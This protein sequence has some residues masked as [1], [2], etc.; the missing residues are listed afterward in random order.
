MLV[1]TFLFENRLDGK[2]RQRSEAFIVKDNKLLVC[3]GRESG[4]PSLPGGK[5]EKNES[6]KTAA[7]RETLE[8]VGIKIKIIRKLKNYSFDYIKEIGPWET[9]PYEITRWDEIGMETHPFLAEYV[10][11]DKSLYNSEGDGKLYKWMTSKE[12]INAFTKL[13]NKSQYFKLR[14]PHIINIVKQLKKDNIIQ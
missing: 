8:E 2:L 4:N 9:L 12:A 1:T 13:M 10:K 7:E 5:I 3:I 14:C 11:E 6:P